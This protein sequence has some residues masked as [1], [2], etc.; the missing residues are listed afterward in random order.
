M[1]KLHFEKMAG[2]EVGNENI[3]AGSTKGWAEKSEQ[4]N[5]MLLLKL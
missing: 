1:E 5:K 4:E 2:A 3:K